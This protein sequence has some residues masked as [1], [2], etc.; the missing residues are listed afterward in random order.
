LPPLGTESA[1][2]SI[3]FSK[4]NSPAHR[5]LCLRFKRHLTMSPARLEARMD[6]L[7]SFPVGLFHPLQHAGLSRRS[8]D[9]RLTGSDSVLSRFAMPGGTT[10][11]DTPMTKASVGV[12]RDR[13]RAVI[14]MTGIYDTRAKRY[15]PTFLVTLPDLGAG[16]LVGGRADSGRVILIAPLP[17]TGLGAPRFDRRSCP[18]AWPRT[19]P[20]PRS[21]SACPRP[22]HVRDRSRY[23]RWWLCERY[24]LRCHRVATPPRPLL[25]PP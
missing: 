25:T 8:P 20:D 21:S 1:S 6:S 5:Y 22:H 7:L 24:G 11:A 2:C 10:S 23:P 3:G 14:R 17:L 18:R 9:C 12:R 15:T 16:W 4:L 19:K 13:V